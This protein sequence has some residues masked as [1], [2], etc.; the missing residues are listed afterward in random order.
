MTAHLEAGS[1]D[2]RKSLHESTI[3]LNCSPPPPTIFEDMAGLWGRAGGRWVA[4]P[5]CTSTSP[6][7]SYIGKFQHIPTYSNIHCH[8]PTYSQVIFNIFLTSPIIHIPTYS[9]HIATSQTQPTNNIAC[10]IT[11]G[12]LRRMMQMNRQ[13][14][15]T[16]SKR[17]QGNQK[18]RSQMRW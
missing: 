18:Q 4:G 7:H 2:H 17:K 13:M 5:K 12:A 11:S 9:Q 1:P 16:I 8:L 10:I 15:R 3:F 6:S 14:A